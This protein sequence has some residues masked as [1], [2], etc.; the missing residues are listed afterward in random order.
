MTGGDKRAGWEALGI[1]TAPDQPSPCPRFTYVGYWGFAWRMPN[2][3]QASEQRA[4]SRQE[5][6]G[7]ALTSS[8]W[9]NG[10][11]L[12]GERRSLHRSSWSRDQALTLGCP[13]SEFRA[14]TIVLVQGCGFRCGN[15]LQ[16]GVGKEG[17]NIP[18]GSQAIVLS[19]RNDQART[20]FLFCFSH[21]SFPIQSL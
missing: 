12:G 3:K 17:Q 18:S 10:A 21:F 16:L 5:L 6:G 15:G 2:L 4:A 20:V 8:G 1:I 14:L 9:S 7:R 11:S 19:G 13:L